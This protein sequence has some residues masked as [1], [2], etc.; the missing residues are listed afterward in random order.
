MA[1]GRVLI[2]TGWGAARAPQRRLA[3]RGSFVPINAGLFWG[4]SKKRSPSHFVEESV[5]EAL[6]GALQQ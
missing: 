1:A 5:L 6:I 4:V 3:L 2:A